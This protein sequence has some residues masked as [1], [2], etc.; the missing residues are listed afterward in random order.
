MLDIKWTCCSLLLFLTLSVQGQYYKITGKITS[1]SGAGI[2][3]AKIDLS[4]GEQTLSDIKGDYEISTKSSKGNYLLRVHSL[5]HQEQERK[6]TL[7]DNKLLRAD[8][9][10]VES[11]NHI[12][13]VEI[14]GRRVAQKIK[15]TGFNV[16]V[17]ETKEFANTNTDIN[18]LLN[19]STGIRIREQGGLGSNFSFSLNGLSGN[20]VRFFMDGI[21][22]ES[23]GSGLSFNNI[24]VNIAERIEVYKGVVP[25]YL[26]SDALGGAINIVTNR[27]KSKFLDLSYS[28]SSF[29]TH[30]TALSA[31]YTEPKTGLR[32]NLNT[33]YNYSDNNYLMRTNPEAGLYLVVPKRTVGDDEFG[34][35]KQ[36]YDTIPSARRFHDSYESYMTQLEVG[37]SNK[38]WADLA[39]LGFTH[40]FVDND[41]QTGATQER[42]LGK[43]HNTTRSFTPSFRY[44]KDRLFTDGL[45]ASM[46]T[47]F[48]NSKSVITDTASYNDY[49]WLGYHLDTYFPNAGE[50]TSN[51]SI[52]HQKNNTFFAQANVNY[53][54]RPNHIFTLN[55][56]VN[57]FTRESYNEIDPYNDFYNKTNRTTQHTTGLNYQQ[58]LLKERLN[59]SFFVKRYTVIGKTQGGENPSTDESTSF[60]GYGAAS[61]FRILEK[62]G[63]KASYEHAYRLPSFVEL[64]GDGINVDASPGLKPVNSDNYNLSLYYQY[65]QGDHDVFFD[66]GLFYRNAK[67]YI[68]NTTYEGQFG[69]RRYSSNEGG[70]KI[71]GADVELRYNYKG[72]LIRAMV[73]LSYYNA[74][75]REKYIK[76][77]NRTKISYGNRTPNEPW[78]YG[79]ADLSTIVRDAFGKKNTNLFINYYLQFVND[80]SLSWSKLGDK[81]TKD[82]IPAQWLHN[83][84]LTYS[85]GMNK[86]NVTI[87]GRN[88]TDEIA[89]DMFKL[90]KPGRSYAIKFRYFLQSIK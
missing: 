38:K 2:A 34:S 49:T 86:Y 7:A 6:I 13:K 90:Q 3:G 4:T 10:L 60:T 16:N 69:T 62:L 50:L 64:H 61:N 73:N 14:T 32:F 81:S 41:V 51:K 39:V 22:I 77:T 54:L 59:N 19:R 40:T 53:A 82:Y 44:R 30:R 42:V 85:F 29:N 27:D 37:L 71:N 52:Q 23:M 55:H 17:I 57:S 12:E 75:D 43:V 63:I 35:V 21:P 18:Q 25:A 79:N 45:S 56:N 9:Q 80:Y 66:G 83:I 89:Y 36:S 84:A 74:V 31:G 33:Y 46:Y 72:G 88:L 20:N 11:A 70:I 8:F 78:L 24:P 15:E 1:T 28:L 26:G 48:S 5:G 47:N 58:V 87:E 76:G 67:D 68:I 65:V